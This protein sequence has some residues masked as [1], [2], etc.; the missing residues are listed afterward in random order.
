VLAVA[1]VGLIAGGLAWIPW[2]PSWGGLIYLL[3]IPLLRGFR[4]VHR[5]R[6][7]ALLATAQ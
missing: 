5:R 7:A 6:R 1:T 3:L 4:M 2:F